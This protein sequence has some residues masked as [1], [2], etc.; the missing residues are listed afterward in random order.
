MSHLVSILQNL[1]PSWSRAFLRRT[2]F[3]DANFQGDILAVISKSYSGMKQSRID[4]FFTTAMIS[5]ALRTGQ[6][7]PQITPCPLVD[8]F[9]LRFQGLEAIHKESQ[10]DYG[11]PQ[12]L[13]L[14]TLK[15]E[16]YMYVSS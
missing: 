16:Q 8:R 2:R 7:L 1:D 3:N 14:D 5:T 15:D 9:M 11:L 13:T 6:P 10:D 4:G 12:Q